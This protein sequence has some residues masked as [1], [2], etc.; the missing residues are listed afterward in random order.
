MAGK[1]ILLNETITFSVVE[2]I[3]VVMAG[4]SFQ[5]DEITTFSVKEFVFLVFKVRMCII[6][7]EMT[8]FSKTIFLS[9]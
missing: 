7:F 6:V 1:S 8:P 2:C 3:I 9:A 5:L 4:E